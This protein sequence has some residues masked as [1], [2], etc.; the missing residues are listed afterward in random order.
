MQNLK[1]TQLG[2]W[3]LVFLVFL[4]LKLTGNLQWSWWWITSP[5]WLPL[6]LFV[7]LSTL[8]FL[9]VVVLILFGFSPE[10]IQEKIKGLGK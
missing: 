10:V 5:L 2:I 1:N 9:V 8:L 4:V 7:A 3:G 6:L